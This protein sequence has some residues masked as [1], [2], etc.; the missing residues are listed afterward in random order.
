MTLQQPLLSA[1]Q[2][3]VATMDAKVVQAAEQQMRRSAPENPLSKRQKTGTESYQ[4]VAR[5]NYSS[6]ESLQ[7]GAQGFIV[8]C[9]FRREK[10]ATKEAVAL[11][12]QYLGLQ[13]TEAHADEAVPLTTATHHPAATKASAAAAAKA[14]AAAAAPSTSDNPASDPCDTP[15]ASCHHSFSI[16]KLASSGIIMLQLNQQASQDSNRHPSESLEG[17]GQAVQQPDGAEAS[18]ENQML[19]GSL[20]VTVVR[21]IVDDLRAGT[22]ATPEFCERIIPVQITCSLTQQALTS[23]TQ[24]LAKLHAKQ[25]VESSGDQLVKFAVAYKSRGSSNKTKQAATPATDSP[26]EPGPANRQQ[27]IT[28]VAAAVEEAVVSAGGKVHVDLKHPQV[29]ILVEVLPISAMSLCAI[30][31]VPASMT[32]QTPKLMIKPLVSSQP[33]ATTHTERS[34]GSL[35]KHM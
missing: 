8:T 9:A 11:I 5:Y 34:K 13:Q 32:V 15:T 23:A 35:H 28:L 10:S 30:S 7:Q 33:P 27:V 2:A 19:P 20:P 17:S 29:V 4:S 14:S 12:S 18:P 16:T 25:A 3:A 6:Q 31:W 24:R 1:D 21:R 22:L 26:Q